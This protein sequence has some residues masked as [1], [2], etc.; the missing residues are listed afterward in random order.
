MKTKI[1]LSAALLSV[2]A[3]LY[4]RTPTTATAQPPVSP[5][6]GSGLIQNSADYNTRCMLQATIV[7]LQHDP[8]HVT[9]DFRPRN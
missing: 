9:M 8:M 2:I 1:A 7:S 3:A 4:V 5:C 6:A